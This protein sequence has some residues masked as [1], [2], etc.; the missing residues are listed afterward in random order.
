MN[1][2]APPHDVASILRDGA[3]IDRAIVA[4]YRRVI[5][6]HRQSK[7]PLAIWR[8]G[9]VVEVP[10]DSVELPGNEDDSEPPVSEH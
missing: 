2:R 3:A 6:R 8:N 9:M 5:L 7:V 4:A 1:L 10:A